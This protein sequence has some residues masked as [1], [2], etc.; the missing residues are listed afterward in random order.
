MRISDFVSPYRCRLRRVVAYGFRPEEI[1]VDDVILHEKHY[2]NPEKGDGGHEGPYD[3]AL[4]HLARPSQ[5]T[6]IS[7]S[8]GD[9]GA[10]ALPDVGSQQLPMLPH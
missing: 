7:I 5:L 2:L 4:L 9:R 1:A 3:I 6:P 10:G 8:E